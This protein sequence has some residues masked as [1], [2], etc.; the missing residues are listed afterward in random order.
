MIAIPDEIRPNGCIFQGAHRR[1]GMMLEQLQDPL[2]GGCFHALKSDLGHGFVTGVPP[3]PYGLTEEKEKDQESHPR[4]FLAPF[5]FG[6]S[7]EVGLLAAAG[8]D[9]VHFTVRHVGGV[10]TPGEVPAFD[11]HSRHGSVAWADNL[12]MPCFCGI[13]KNS[14]SAAFGGAVSAFRHVRT[15]KAHVI[16]LAADISLH[17]IP[18]TGYLQVFRI[19]HTDPPFSLQLIL[20]LV[21]EK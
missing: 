4:A 16:L 11:F 1:V 7:F 6:L 9:A 12:Q 19:V 5:V 13:N 15:G 10:G 18:G 17:S 14:P 8:L 2:S 3:R 20:R 21:K